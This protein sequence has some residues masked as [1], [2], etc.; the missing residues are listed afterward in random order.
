MCGLTMRRMWRRLRRMDNMS[1]LNDVVE[2]LAQWK[3]HWRD[4]AEGAGVPYDTVAKVAQGRTKN[5]GILTVDR[6]RTHLLL[7]GNPPDAR[8]QRQ[9]EA[10]VGGATPTAEAA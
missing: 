10:Q 3:G 7:I 4:I 5:P 1:I 6:L 2:R 8:G 9:I